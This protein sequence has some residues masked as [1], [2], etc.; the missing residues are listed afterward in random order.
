MRTF[1][2]DYTYKEFGQLETQFNLIKERYCITVFNVFIL[3]F[4][5]KTHN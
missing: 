2:T 5:K 1:F 3:T 4:D